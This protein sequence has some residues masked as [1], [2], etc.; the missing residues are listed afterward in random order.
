M[1]ATFC[2]GLR[3]R[4]KTAKSDAQAMRPVPPTGNNSAVLSNIRA[5]NLRLI[6]N[7]ALQKQI[8]AGMRHAFAP[9]VIG[10]LMMVGQV[11]HAACYADY[12]ARKDNPLQLHYGVAQVQGAC[13]KDTATTQ[14]R[15]RLAAAGWQLLTVVSVFDDAGLPSRQGAAGAFFLRF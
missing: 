8:V 4:P 5:L 10:A 9:F 2:G 13:T 1:G 3:P 15:P 6:L 12:K 11:A 14:L 7:N